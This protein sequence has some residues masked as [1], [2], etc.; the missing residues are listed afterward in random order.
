MSRKRVERISMTPPRAIPNR[1][2]KYRRRTKDKPSAV[3][4]KDGSDAGGR[5]G[6]SRVVV[7]KRRDY[8]GMIK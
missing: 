3:G 1:P 7:E 4:P 5:P 6:P 2:G 8:W